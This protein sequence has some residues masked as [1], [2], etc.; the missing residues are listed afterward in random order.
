M[1]KND[2]YTMK[3]EGG[4][5]SIDVYNAIVPPGL[6]E[7]GHSAASFKADLE[8][9]GEVSSIDLHINSPG[10]AVFE[11]I[12][13]YNTL[14]M[15]PAQVTT[16]VDGL[17][18]SIASVIAMAGDVIR[19][20]KNA[21][22]MIHNPYMSSSGTSSEFRKKADELDKVADSM[23]S[24]YLG[25]TGDK[26]SEPD[27]I[28]KMEEETWLNGKEAKDLGFCDFVIEDSPIVASLSPEWAAQY[29]HPPQAVIQ[30]NT[31]ASK[32]LIL[33]LDRI[34]IIGELDQLAR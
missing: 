13:I 31:E 18:A 17:A 10:G 28:Q 22:I 8:A 26:L 30:P 11:G 15:H 2:F 25:K 34:K 1:G 4:K 5:A 3:A 21:K 9:L 32:K 7:F 23:R 33:E 6:E 19:M 20:P 24:I 29:R 27:L 12:A 16:Y 14:K